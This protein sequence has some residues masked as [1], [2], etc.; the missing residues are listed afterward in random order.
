MEV[1]LYDEEAIVRRIATDVLAAMAKRASAYID[2]ARGLA[3]I[4]QSNKSAK[5]SNLF[6]KYV[7]PGLINAL[8]DDDSNVREAA[9]TFRTH[10][11]MI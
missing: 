4:I 8:G 6:T 1:A 2:R 7:V 3:D 5:L 11:K 10:E 9:L